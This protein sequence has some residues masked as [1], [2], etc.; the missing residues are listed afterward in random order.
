MSLV[1]NRYAEGLFDLALEKN[2]IEKYKANLDTV[3]NVF[4]EVDN[5]KAFF[6]SE[7]ISKEDKKKLIKDSFDS[8]LEKDVLHFLYLLV[9]KKR[10]VY[11][12]D[13]VTSYNHLANEEL[14]IIEGTIESPRPLDKEKIKELEKVLAKNGEKI[15]LKQ[16]INKSL[17]SGFK[18]KLDNKVID[19]S[20]KDRI[21]K[22]HNVL[23]RKEG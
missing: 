18:I 2:A 4:D 12:D 3:K 22:M 9:D 14:N 1:A 13:I 21:N 20:M 11:Y 10:I 6:A 5:I 8:K 17:I 7:R 19:A 16:K 23:S 15:E